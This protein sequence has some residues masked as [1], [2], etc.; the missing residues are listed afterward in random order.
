[1]P[2]LLEPEVYDDGRPVGP[3]RIAD[4][5]VEVELDRSAS[6]ESVAVDHPPAAGWPAFGAFALVFKV[7]GPP[8]TSA[9]GEGVF[10][11][12]SGVFLDAYGRVQEGVHAV[13]DGISQVVLDV[14]PGPGANSIGWLVWHIARVQDDHVAGVAGREQV[15]I[16]DGW[17]ERFGLAL[18]P[19]DIGYGHTPEQV[20]LVRGIAPS[21]LRDYYDAV[22]DVTV[23]YLSGLVA[24]DLDRVV[25]TNWDP[26]V[27]LGVR[28]V[29]V[30]DDN[31]QHSGQAAY[32]RGLLEA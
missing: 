21:D 18:E 31:Q 13:L 10:V 23:E 7:V 16:A 8:S 15:W 12:V 6:G 19:N 4:V 1:M 11:E 28:L 3:E 2:Y 26:H 27:T 20:E 29:S 32:V 5:V 22:H 9:A 24:A 17:Q 30:V 25:D 14:R